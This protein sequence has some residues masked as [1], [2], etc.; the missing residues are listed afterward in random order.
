MSLY[1]SIC[2]WIIILVDRYMIYFWGLWEIESLY[3]KYII[4]DL[5]LILVVIFKKLFRI[6]IYFNIY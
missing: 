1:V 2:R 3:C 5:K 4:D 6:F